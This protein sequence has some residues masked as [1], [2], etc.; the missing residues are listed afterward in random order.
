MRILRVRLRAAESSI[1][2]LGRFYVDELG[3]PAA[4]DGFRAGATT[5]EFVPT[6]DGEPF[7][8]FAFRVPRNRFAVARDWLARRSELLSDGNSAETTFDFASWNAEACYAHDPAGNIVEVIAHRE[9]PEETL[10]DGPFTGDEVLSVCELGLVGPD[11][12]AMAATLEP[13]G[14]RLW[15]GTLAGPGGLAFM[16]GRE[17]L[18][19]LA[20]TGRG[21]MPTGRPGEA[22]EVD[23]VVTGERD[24]EVMLPGTSHRVRTRP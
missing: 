6:A 1:P 19:I 13:L 22:H 10:E 20:S 21:W 18:L 24:V 5:V 3:L 16:G 17:G 14:I 23:V 11:K 12:R 15:D 8:H 4:A 2:A 7:Y 9:L